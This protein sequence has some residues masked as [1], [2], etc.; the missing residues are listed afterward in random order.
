MM[1]R[2]LELTIT[3]P[4]CG[5]LHSVLVREADYNRFVT[6]EYLVQD[7][8]PYL[9]ATEREALISGLCPACQSSIFGEE[10]EEDWD[11]EDLEDD[12]LEDIFQAA[13]ARAGWA[14]F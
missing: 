11:E 4:F 3:C 8:F 10:P 13:M 1:T 2:N 6:G 12:D 9:N 5:K 7:V 14:G